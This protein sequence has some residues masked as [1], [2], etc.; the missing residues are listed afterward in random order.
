MIFA[1]HVV[2]GKLWSDIILPER[3]MLFPDFSNFIVA[4][5]SSPKNKYGIFLSYTTT[6]EILE[7][8]ELGDIIV[9]RGINVMYCGTLEVN[10][11]PLATIK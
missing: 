4:H 5:M 10:E 8:L 2:I 9:F 7:L 3:L 6:G 1:N 11:L